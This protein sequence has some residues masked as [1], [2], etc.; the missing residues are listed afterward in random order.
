MK[1]ASTEL[2]DGPALIILHGLFG[3]ARNWST[4]ARRL[5][6]SYRVI[7]LDL[8][9]HGDSPW[10]GTMTYAEVADD[11]ADFIAA[12]GLDRR[13][14]ASVGQL[15]PRLDPDAE[16]ARLEAQGIQALTW[17]DAG[18]P[19]MLKEIYDPPP[20]LYV[21]GELRPEDERAVAVWAPAGLRPTVAR[22][23]LP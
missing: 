21:K 5:A 15:R 2:G 12:A 9:N 10:A 6:A 18:Y 16:M 13:V 11:V 22:P 23:A 14:V 8:R 3:S 20:V 19:P 17:K 1:L 7:A 4:I